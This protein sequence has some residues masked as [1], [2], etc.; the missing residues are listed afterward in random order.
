MITDK[1]ILAFATSF[2]STHEVPFCTGVQYGAI[3]ATG[4]AVTEI[5]ELAEV[6]NTLKA[7]YEDLIR[8]VKMDNNHFDI[9]TEEKAALSR[10]DELIKKHSNQ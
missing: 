8:A 9:T 1:E 4:R 3:W 10:A 5:G 2:R 6:L 7:S